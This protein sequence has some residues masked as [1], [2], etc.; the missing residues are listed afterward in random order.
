MVRWNADNAQQLIVSIK[1]SCIGVRPTAIKYWIETRL[2]GSD[3]M[4]TEAEHA[5]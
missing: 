1:H 3:E 2:E 5:G 4:S